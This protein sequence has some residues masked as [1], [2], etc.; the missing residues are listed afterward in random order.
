MGL[1]P[2]LAR[3]FPS[4]GERVRCQGLTTGTRGRATPGA[5]PGRGQ[6]AWPGVSPRVEDLQQLPPPPPR[7]RHSPFPGRPGARLPAPLKATLGAVCGASVFLSE[8][9]QGGPARGWTC[10]PAEPPQCRRGC[11]D[12][13]A[14]GPGGSA[15]GGP[16]P[17]GWKPRGRESGSPRPRRVPAAA[18]GQRRGAG[19][20][21]NRR[22]SGA[23]GAGPFNQSQRQ[24][25]P[26][27]PSP[28]VG[29]QTA[30]GVVGANGGQSLGG[31]PR[32]ET[33]RP[34]AR[35]LG[36]PSGRPPRRARSP[37]RGAGGS[38]GHA[39]GGRPG[40]RLLWPSRR[41]DE[42]SPARPAAPGLRGGLQLGAAPRRPQNYSQE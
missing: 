35:V 15:G 5:C 31:G 30:K 41:R 1:P 23:G 6:R 33:H 29:R 8:E 20:P 39:W 4:R 12:I 28:S 19:S 25:H 14:A 16:G 38:R 26:A 36:P 27:A 34:P 18:G 9:P 40:T 21:R 42:R 7:P 11:R 2:A 37:A 3:L 17:A 13:P 32:C 10:C 22:S 24:K